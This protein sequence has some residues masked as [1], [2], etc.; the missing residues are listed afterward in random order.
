MYR[1][2]HWNPVILDEQAGGAAELSNDMRAAV[3]AGDAKVRLAVDMFIPGDC[4][5]CGKVSGEGS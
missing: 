3:K 2:C 5:P 4:E 1:N